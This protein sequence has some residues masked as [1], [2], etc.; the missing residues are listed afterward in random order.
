MLVRGKIMAIAAASLSFGVLAALAAGCGTLADGGG[1][2]AN[3]PSAQAGPFR[4][5]RDGEIGDLRSEPYA[6]DDDEEFV[7]DPFI[8]DDDGDPSTL[9]AIVFVARHELAEDEEPDKDAPTNLIQRHTTRDGRTLD[10]QPTAVVRAERDWEE[11]WVGAPSAVQRGGETWL[12]Y[13]AGQGIGLARGSGGAQ[14]TPEESP[15]L[16]APTEGWDAGAIPRSPGV[17]VMPDGSVRLFYEVDHGDTTKIGEARSDDGVAWTRVGDGP[18]LAPSAQGYDAAA[19]GSPQPTITAA[20]D[21][22]PRMRLYYAAT[23][24]D[25]TRTIGMAA[26]PG[27]SGDFRRAVAPVFGLGLPF[28]PREPSVVHYE[29]FA[30]LFVTQRA[31]RNESLDFPAIAVGVSPALV[32]LPP[33]D[34]E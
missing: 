2:D 11:G 26:R 5:L 9:G 34:P 3:L 12:Y 25:G 23:G 4:P 22:A 32:T 18:A 30:L 21:G 13:A 19:V 33:P 27:T 16:V 15:V 17:T 24:G 14:F 29:D 20:P 31:G 7:R 10:R 1:G 8:M 28:A 6:I